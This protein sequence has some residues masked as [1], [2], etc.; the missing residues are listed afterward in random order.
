[1]R[2]VRSLLGLLLGLLA[3][4][5][6][7]IAQSPSAAERD[8]STVGP[9]ERRGPHA[10]ATGTLLNSNGFSGYPRLIRLAH[11]GDANG[12]ILASVTGNTGKDVGLIFESTD[13]GKTFHQIAEIPNTPDTIDDG[14][15]WGTIYELPQQVG[16]LPAGT[17]L[18]VASVGNAMP[19][20]TRT[21]RQRIWRS[22]DHG[23]TWSFLSDMA[24]AP[25]HT[26]AYEPELTVTKDGDLAGFWSDQTEIGAA[27]DQK[28]SKVFSP[29][30]INWSQPE[31]LV[32][33]TDSDR[34]V[35]PGMPIVRTLPN[36]TWFMVYEV[37]NLDP[38]HPCA[39]YYRTSPD[40]YNYGDPLDPGTQIKTTRSRYLR[41]TPNLTWSPGP[42]PNGTIVLA[43]EMLV[44]ENGDIAP[45]NGN[46]IVANDNLGQGDWYEITSPVKVDGVDNS[47]CKNF[48][49]AL[50]PTRDGQVL[51]MATDYFAENDCRSYYA[52]GPL[53]PR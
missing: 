22:D 8:G 29:D 23:R 14:V 1:M 6:L 33:A 50:L 15:G 12:R 38:V 18:R 41:H 4:S 32:T 17:I 31:D 42:G 36:G 25:N 44:E 5:S 16:D 37:C 35:R 28:M 10:A 52:T 30:G 3:V 43:S 13:D 49:P 46:T 40:G 26:N 9:D 11:S 34:G 45:E 53:T 20:D 2:R 19:D 48:S 27:H 7:V 47:G 24:I 39:I 51:E 21:V